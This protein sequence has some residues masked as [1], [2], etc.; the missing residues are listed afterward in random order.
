M[1]Q[2]SSS[3]LLQ[4]LQI[5]LFTNLHDLREDFHLLTKTDIY[6]IQVTVNI[7]ILQPPHFI[8]IINIR[9]EENPL[10]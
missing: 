1:L 9:S 6:S 5:V 3:V 2:H 8:F 7:F 10:F 4:K